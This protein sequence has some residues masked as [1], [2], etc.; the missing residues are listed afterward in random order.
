[1]K[2]IFLD[3]DGVLNIPP[4][5]GRD[6]FGHIFNNKCVKNLE[7]IIKQ[8]SAK[9]VVSSTWRMDG[10]DVIKQLW[11]E[12]SL[13]GEII[14]CTPR[15][16]APR[17]MTNEELMEYRGRGL[18]IEEYINKHGIKKYCII[19][20]DSDMLPTQMDYFV[21]CNFKTGLTKSLADLSIDILNSI[22]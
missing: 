20:D 12:R 18:E 11:K 3:F 5:L 16:H 17:T 7:T 15:C 2:V 1:M 6:K 22:K 8:T 9:I 21:K 10:T 13:P 4:Y 14:G 19:D